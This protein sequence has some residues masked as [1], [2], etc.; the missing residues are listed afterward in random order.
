MH[1]S[2]IIW[3]SLLLAF[4]YA[5]R[6]VLERTFFGNIYY[7]IVFPG[8][9]VHELSHAFTCLISGAQ[10]HSIK[11]FSRSGGQVTHSQSKIPI[12][13]PFLI[14]MAPI[15]GATAGLYLICRLFAPSF[16]NLPAFNFQFS[17][18]LVGNFIN[19]FLQNLKTLD[20]ANWQTYIF[21]YL[22]LSL[23]FA[24]SPSKEDL[25]NTF[26]SLIFIFVIFGILSLVVSLNFLKPI[27]QFLGPFYIFGIGME[28][29]AI[30][31]IGFFHA[32]QRMF[33]MI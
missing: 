23:S 27:L 28:I 13:G 32:I 1:F 10:I 6:Y 15:F 24:M 22:V 18:D 5:L 14:A 30:V 29:M 8:V 20:W 4:G 17:Q 11:L 16:L 3:L 12:L 21:M 7:V 19:H 33:K 26:W 2:F 9:V 31:V 25:Q